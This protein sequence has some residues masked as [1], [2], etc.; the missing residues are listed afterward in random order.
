MV[1]SASCFAGVFLEIFVK[2]F[3]ISANVMSDVEKF[4][5]TDDCDAFN[6]LFDGKDVFSHICIEHGVASSVIESAK[7]FNVCSLTEIGVCV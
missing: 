5:V 6:V 2:D 1:N 3:I 4:I 7:E